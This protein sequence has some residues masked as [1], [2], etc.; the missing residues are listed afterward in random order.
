[1]WKLNLHLSFDSKLHSKLH[2]NLHS[3]LH[4]TFDSSYDPAV[5]GHL[6]PGGEGLIAVRQRGA[7]GQHGAVRQRRVAV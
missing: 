7:A 5:P 3:N 1:M 2:S 6:H 4:L